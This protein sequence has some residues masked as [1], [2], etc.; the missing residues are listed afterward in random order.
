MKEMIIAF[1][2]DDR[3]LIYSIIGVQC[4]SPLRWRMQYSIHLVFLLQV[5]SLLF[6]L[7]PL[8]TTKMWNMKVRKVGE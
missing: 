4:R 3:A 8:K 7:V 1:D 5:S 2:I 6:I